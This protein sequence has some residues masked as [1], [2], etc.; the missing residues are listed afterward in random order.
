MTD[1]RT[2]RKAI[3]EDIEKIQN[4]LKEKNDAQRDM[5]Q[6]QLRGLID[7]LKKH[8]IDKQN[9]L[10]RYIDRLQQLTK[11]NVACSL[12]DT[13]DSQLKETGDD[14]TKV[15]KFEGDD[16]TPSSDPKNSGVMIEINMRLYKVVSKLE[17]I[18]DTVEDIMKKY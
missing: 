17:I 1:K 13:L 11:D 9:K 5:I 18:E 4:G 2:L 15:L 16:K 10:D 6:A 12:L 8:I 14:Y 3:L 7:L